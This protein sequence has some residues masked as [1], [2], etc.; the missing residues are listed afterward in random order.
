MAVLT[1]TINP[2]ESLLS[3]KPGEVSWP[4]GIDATKIDTVRILALALEISRAFTPGITAAAD[5]LDLTINCDR[6]N[7]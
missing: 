1:K 5:T 4:A 7:D 6:T 2:K 3:G